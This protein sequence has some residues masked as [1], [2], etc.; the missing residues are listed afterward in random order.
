M[1]VD[2]DV[3]VEDVEYGEECAWSSGGECG[4]EVDCTVMRLRISE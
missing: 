2:G 1:S 4:M 3:D